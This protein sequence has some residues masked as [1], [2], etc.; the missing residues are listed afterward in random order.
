MQERSVSISGGAVFW[1]LGATH[2]ATLMD[3]LE[4][5]GLG[6][7]VPPERTPK[8]ALQDA[9]N[10]LFQDRITLI[11]PL[12]KRDA[13]AVVREK[14]GQT[15][16]QYDTM[17][18]ATVPEGSDLVIV[19]PGP[20]GPPAEF[21]DKFLAVQ[22]AYAK[23]KG[24]MPGTAVATML[25][26][27]VESMNGITLRPT[28][29]FYWLP[30]EKLT[31]W[32]AIAKIVEGSAI[33]SSQMWVMRTAADESTLKAVHDSVISH[34][35]GAATKIE[36]EIREGGLGEKALTARAG[37]SKEL[38]RRLSEYE[39]LLGTKLTDV[40]KQLADI[41]ILTGEAVMKASS[42]ALDDAAA[43]IG[44]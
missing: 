42:A 36:A 21:G 10:E 13:F 32:E 20:D 7:F 11:R 29:G 43:A 37:A 27:I 38:R 14:R 31:R 18:T 12:E 5:A 23:F 17:L 28:G 1:S 2:R 41:D 19:E 34:I 44:A 6:A 40:A 35:G 4:A 9:L 39:R 16:N 33:E 26:A 30:D 22:T 25:V 15:A 24:I 8:A 3:G